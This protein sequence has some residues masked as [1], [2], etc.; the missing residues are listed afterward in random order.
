MDEENIVSKMNAVSQEINTGSM[1][2]CIVVIDGATLGSFESNSTL[3]SVFMK[4]CTKTDSVIC[5]RA[6]PS[7]KGSYTSKR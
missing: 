4:L 6:S 1:A 2:H 3:M 5:C 7:Q